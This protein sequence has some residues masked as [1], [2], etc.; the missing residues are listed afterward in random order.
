YY[1]EYDIHIQ[2]GGLWDNEEAALVYEFGAK[3]VMMGENDD[4]AFHNLFTRTAPPAREP[5][6]IVDLGCGFGKST[7]P[8]ARAYPE[9]EVVGIDLSAPVLRLAHAQA[10][11]LGLEIRFVQADGAATPMDDESVDLVT[12]T[13]FIHEIP[14]DGLADVFTEVARVLAPGGS[15]RILDFHL[16]GDGPRDL[17]MREHGVRNNEPVMPMLFDTDLVAI[18]RE[19]GL[20]ARWVAFDE[21]GHGRREDL[22]WPR[23]PE[24]HFPWAV[25]EAEKPA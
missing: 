1:T 23:R 7:R 20:Q 10:A 2:P 11:D 24:W 25:F 22:T 3:V 21:T 4:H 17:A 19:R 13:M 12:A 14:P 16:T 5:R 8:F 9:A 18:C 6:R 15:V